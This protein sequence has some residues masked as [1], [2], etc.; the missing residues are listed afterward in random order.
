MAFVE[1]F[2]DEPVPARAVM[3][4]LYGEPDMGK[5]SLSMQVENRP[6]IHLDFDRA[7]GRAIKRKRSVQ[8]GSWSEM[9]EQAYDKNYFEQFRGGVAIIDTA[10]A[11]MDKYM[12]NALISQDKT[13]ANKTGGLS[14]QGFGALKTLF[15]GFKNK[16]QSYDI[17]LIVICHEQTVTKKGE[18]TR[19]VPAV[20]GGSLQILLGEA[21]LVGYMSSRND[22]RTIDFFPTDHHVGKNSP[23]IPLMTVPDASSPEYLN[24]MGRLLQMVKDKFAE[25]TAAMDASDEYQAEKRAFLTIA[26]KFTGLISNAAMILD[27]PDN[28]SEPYRYPIMREFIEKAIE[29]LPADLTFETTVEDANYLKTQISELAKYGFNDQWLK[30]LKGALVAAAKAVGLVY[31]QGA[32]SFAESED[33]AKLKEAA[34]TP[35]TPAPINEVG[36]PLPVEAKTETE[37]AKAAEKAKSEK[38]TTEGQGS[39]FGNQETTASNQKKRNP[40]KVKGAV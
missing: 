13:L 19:S 34:E 28:V 8:I 9:V 12:S 23:K 17:D 22:V 40:D 14:L 31:P 1:I 15:E 38:P 25:R 27:K 20:T 7:L 37:P 10:K 3:V 35:A 5:T 24:Q 16:I 6:V 30:P 18:E 11:M 21:D 36:E 26:E 29:L 33:R 4:V 32:T 39:L 2:P